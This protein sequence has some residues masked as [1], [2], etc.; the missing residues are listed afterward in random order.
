MKSAA[1]YYISHL[2]GEPHMTSLSC[3]ARFSKWTCL[4][5]LKG[6]PSEPASLALA[7]GMEYEI[8]SH[9]FLS[10]FMSYFVNS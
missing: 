2:L 8:D 7:I 9:Q 6:M 5:K 3:G 1:K 4:V 10:Q